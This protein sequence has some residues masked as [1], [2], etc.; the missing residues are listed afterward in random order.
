MRHMIV[1]SIRC[2]APLALLVLA[3]FSGA[4]AA[5]QLARHNILVIEHDGGQGA[6]Q[7]GYGIIEDVTATLKR[8]LNARFGVYDI[9]AFSNV[10]QL[11]TFRRQGYDVPPAE[12]HQLTTT[13]KTPP[14]D[15]LLTYKV[16]LVFPTPPAP[17]PGMPHPGLRPGQPAADTMPVLRVTATLIRTPSGEMVAPIQLPDMVM[18]NLTTPCLR[19]QR[20][21]TATLKAAAEPIGVA[22]SNEVADRLASN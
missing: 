20:C 7:R 3:L 13:I 5:A 21:L 18:R 14:I 16:L 19:D 22:L 10:F 11:Q 17:V 8:E 2:G 9:T 1:R 6:V 12:V 4:P 15:M